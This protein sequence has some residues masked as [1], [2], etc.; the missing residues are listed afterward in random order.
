MHWIVHNLSC[1][2]MAPCIFSKGAPNE[3]QGSNCMSRFGTTRR[4]LEL[5]RD[6]V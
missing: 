1:L 6:E 3:A 4:P 5:C 2:M